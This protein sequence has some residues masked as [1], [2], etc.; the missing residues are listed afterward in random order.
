M[1]YKKSSNF[2]VLL[3]EN[4][5][6]QTKKNAS[7]PFSI[8]YFSFPFPFDIVIYLFAFLLKKIY[9]ILFLKILIKKRNIC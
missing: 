8:L 4:G 2:L 6:K 1:L 3:L 9:K 5:Q 7:S